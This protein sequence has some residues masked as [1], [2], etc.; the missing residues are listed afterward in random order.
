MRPR[1]L[2]WTTS[3]WFRPKEPFS[4]PRHYVRFDRTFDPL[5]TYLNVSSIMVKRTNFPRSGTTSDVGG[6]ISASS[7]KNT[8]SDSRMEMDRLTYKVNIATAIKQRQT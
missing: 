6:M 5:R 4:F 7:K 3:D 2:A 8:V 1:P